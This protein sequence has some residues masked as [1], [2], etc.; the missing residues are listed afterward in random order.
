[1]ATNTIETGI[2]PTPA[3]G[4]FQRSKDNGMRIDLSFEADFV[5]VVQQFEAAKYYRLAEK[6]GNKIIGNTW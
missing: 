5:G 3:D 1:M 2:F 6:N 4:S